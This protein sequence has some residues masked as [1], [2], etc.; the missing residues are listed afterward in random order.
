MESGATSQVVFPLVTGLFFN[1]I[2]LVVKRVFTML[3]AANLEQLEENN[4]RFTDMEDDT[5]MDGADIEQQDF[6]S[7]TFLEKSMEISN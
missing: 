5:N 7:K 2:W 6:D 3:R 1:A 4:L